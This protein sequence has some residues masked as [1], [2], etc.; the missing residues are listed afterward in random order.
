M[1]YQPIFSQN[2]GLLEG[3]SEIDLTTLA[4]VRAALEMEAVRTA[5]DAQLS[6]LITVASVKAMRLMNRAIWQKARTEY[7]DVLPNVRRFRVLAS[8]IT[9]A[10]SAIVAYNNT[11]IPRAFTAAGD[12]IDTDYI[13]I[14]GHGR[15]QQGI[16]D[17]ETSLSPGRNALS[18]T[19]TG[20][21]AAGVAVGDVTTAMVANYP[22]LAGFLDIQVSY[23]MRNRK[24]FEV[25]SRSIVGASTTRVQTDF[26]LRSVEA[27]IRG[28]YGR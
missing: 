26:W 7:F 14:S 1:T 27:G 6:I 25:T 23:M 3:E 24:S 12:L 28:L 20:G 16:I 2:A 15:A 8:P 22:A 9:S 10:A 13:I 19:Y 17:F 5:D 4:R 18:I 11:D 21:M